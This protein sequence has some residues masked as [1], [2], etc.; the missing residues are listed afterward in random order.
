MHLLAVAEDIAD[1]VEAEASR[2]KVPV[3]VCVRSTSTGTSSSA[4]LLSRTSPFSRRGS[5]KPNSW[6]RQL[7]RVRRTPAVSMAFR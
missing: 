7:C 6:P 3:A 4:R 1:R 2:A 5:E